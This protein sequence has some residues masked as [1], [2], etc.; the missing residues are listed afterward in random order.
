MKYIT[1]IFYTEKENKTR[2]DK[3]VY[4][5]NPC[6]IAKEASIFSKSI[7]SEFFHDNNHA[8]NVHVRTFE[9]EVPSYDLR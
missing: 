7:E 9:L 2:R 8:E 3:V 1:A 5:E 6:D 4:F